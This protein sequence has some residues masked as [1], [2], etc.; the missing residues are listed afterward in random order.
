[1]NRQLFLLIILLALKAEAQTSALNLADSLHAVGKYT[2][3]IEE[4]EKIEPRTEAVLV[5]LAKAQQSGGKPMAALETYRTIL[6][7]NPGRVLTV[8]NYGKL[9]S[10]TGK[11]KEADSVFSSLIKEHPGNASFHYQLGLVKEKR[12]DSTAINYFSMTTILDR[13]HQQA[14][15]KVAKDHLSHR[16]YAQAEYFSKQG[17]ETNPTNP[18]LLSILAQTHYNQK[19]YKPASEYFG[20]LVELGHGS[21]FVH[22]KLAFAYFQLEQPKEAIEQYSAALNYEEGNPDTHHSLGKLFA[23]TGEYEESE[24][25]LLLA[26]LLKKQPVDAEFLSLGLTYKFK[27]DYKNALK[28]FNLSLEENPQNE[29]ALYE[30]AIAADNYYEDLETKMNYYQAYLNRFEKRGDRN[31]V[32]L[33]KRRIKDIREELHLDQ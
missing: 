18:S 10:T 25:H 32:H 13:N 20:K 17:L 7:E 31:L 11:L 14:L 26:V 15:F 27:E 3:A 21:E 5:K 23:Y 4:L 2:A 16:R 24:K 22:T 1:M 19:E 9:L 29:R 33:A 12:K 28:Y 30:R 6:D 8:L